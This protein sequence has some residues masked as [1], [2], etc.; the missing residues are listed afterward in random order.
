LA[1]TQTGDAAVEL[2]VHAFLRKLQ[3][4]MKRLVVGE[5]ILPVWSPAADSILDSDTVAHLIA[6]QMPCLK[7]KPNLLLHDLGSFTRDELLDKRLKNIFMANN[8]T[9]VFCISSYF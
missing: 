4:S 7:G 8:H 3:P 2:E 6:L 9:Y 5:I 1:P